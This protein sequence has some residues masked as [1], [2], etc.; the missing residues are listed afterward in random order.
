MS[1]VVVVSNTAGKISSAHLMMI[2]NAT[3]EV[4]AAKCRIRIVYKIHRTAGKTHATA[5]NRIVRPGVM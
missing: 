4:E 3:T 2:S 5:I 1:R